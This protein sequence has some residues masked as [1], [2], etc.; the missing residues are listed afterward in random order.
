MMLR[1]GVMKSQFHMIFY[2]DQN[3]QFYNITGL[4]N[5][6]KSH[7]CYLQKHT[8]NDFQVFISPNR[9]TPANFVLSEQFSTT[10]A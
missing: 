10:G 1:H 3:W 4:F 8:K 7:H 9:P 6:L 5:V 2:I